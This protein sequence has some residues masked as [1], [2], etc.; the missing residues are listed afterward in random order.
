M[1]VFRNVGNVAFLLIGIS[2]IYFATQEKDDLI[3]AVWLRVI[4]FGLLIVGVL[5][6]MT[7]LFK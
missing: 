7:A 1:E 6:G 4:G 5:S 2:L 3:A